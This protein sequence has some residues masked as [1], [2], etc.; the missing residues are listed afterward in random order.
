MKHRNKVK[1]KTF[2]NHHK[3]HPSNPGCLL[4]SLKLQQ[5][6]HQIWKIWAFSQFI[7]HSLPGDFQISTLNLLFLWSIP[8]CT[9]H[10]F[11][12]DHIYPKC[13]SLCLEVSFDSWVSL[14]SCSLTWGENL[15]DSSE[16]SEKNIFPFNYLQFAWF[17]D[18][19]SKVKTNKKI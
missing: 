1:V 11:T 18:F 13:L 17:L 8:S 15:G 12:V 5:L 16:R 19:I 14:I 10:G 2:Q 3:Q 7:S 6:E 9:L 4:L